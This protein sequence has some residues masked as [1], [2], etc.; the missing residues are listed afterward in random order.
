[1]KLIPLIAVKETINVKLGGIVTYTTDQK[2]DG[3]GII[4]AA[5]E[6]GEYGMVIVDQVHSGGEVIVTM[7]PV[8]Q[9]A[10]KYNIG[11]K[12]GYLAVF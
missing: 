1:M 2:I 11:E 10:K 9:P 8:V 12:I 3:E 5:N 6:T 7:R 4:L